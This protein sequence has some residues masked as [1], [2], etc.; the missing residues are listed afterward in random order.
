[1][2]FISRVLWLAS[3]PAVTLHVYGAVQ[4]APASPGVD[5]RPAGERSMAERRSRRTRRG[6]RGGLG[7]KVWVIGWLALIATAGGQAQ[8]TREERLCQS[9]A[10]HLERLEA[11]PRSRP[12]TL[13]QARQQYR[14]RCDET[15]PASAPSAAAAPAPVPPPAAPRPRT[16]G[17][18]AD[19]NDALDDQCR[20]WTDG[21]AADRRTRC[22]QLKIDRALAEQR[23]ERTEVDACT[24]D[25]AAAATSPARSSS[26]RQ[27]ELMASRMAR[28]GGPAHWAWEGHGGCRLAQRVRSTFS[29]LDLPPAI[30]ARGGTVSEAEAR[31]RLCETDPRLPFCAG[32]AAAASAGGREQPYWRWQSQ[33]YSQCLAEPAAGRA[34]DHCARSIVE[35][36]LSEGRAAP[37]AVDACRARW[38]AGARSEPEMMAVEQCLL[39][40][41]LLEQ[42]AGSRAAEAAAGPATGGPPGLNLQG[43]SRADLVVPLYAGDLAKVPAGAED[44][45]YMLTSF[46]RLNESCPN[47]GLAG[48][49][50]RIAQAQVRQTQEAVVR[51]LSG[52]GS[53]ADAL[54]TLGAANEMMK[55][56]PDCERIVDDEPRRQAC[57]AERDSA[58]QVQRSPAAV[59]DATRLIERH[60]CGSVQM[61]RYAQ[62]LSAW[63][64]APPG[65]R[66]S[67]AGL[68]QHPQAPALARLFD[69]CRRQAGDGV[70][71]AWCG[72]YVRNFANAPRGTRSAPAEVLDAAAHSAFIGGPQ[73]WYAPPDIGDCQPYWPAI[74]RWRR[75]QAARALVTAC[76]VQQQPAEVVL[77]PDVKR[78]RYRSGA[79]FVELRAAQCPARL[80][81]HEWG[82]EPV[83][84]GGAAGGR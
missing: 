38:Q 66:G 24:A 75:E 34:R 55:M 57:I 30:A 44:L 39:A 5:G 54:T 18:F 52:R 59:A 33:A 73:A 21:D 42:A 26:A 84:C 67:L 46:G 82:H 23:L 3:N 74:E 6:R 70:A 37:A 17:R 29:D 79:G 81:A 45:R 11:S 9:M 51:G 28:L 68:D 7:A 69:N 8:G 20:Q 32:A 40:L 78:C 12:E 14:Q 53:T 48:T 19:W 15:A 58:F 41:A 10:R 80:H 56:L 49:A 36:A 72:C 71:D 27:R 60:G 2:F 13:A 50:M 25:A 63:L 35:R 16:P 31:A 43:L 65:S 62:Q 61:T 83:P 77:A 76:L 4:Q 64:L 47:L 22:A 1:M